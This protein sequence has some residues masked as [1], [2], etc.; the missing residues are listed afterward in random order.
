MIIFQKMKTKSQNTQAI[1]DLNKCPI[2]YIAV[3]PKWLLGVTVVLFL[4]Y[5]RSPI[6]FLEPRFWAEEG[7]G[8]FSF[9]FSHSILES[10]FAPHYGYYGLIQNLGGILATFVPLEYAPLVTTCLAGLIQLL[11]SSYVFF[12]DSP[13]WDTFLKK[14]TIACCIQILCPYECW[15]TTISSQ[16]FLSILAFFILTENAVTQKSKLKWP[17][18]IALSLASLTSP[19]VT[20]LLPAFA[21]KSFKTRLRE[22]WLRVAIISAG[23]FIQ[24]IAFIQTCINSSAQFGGRFRADNIGLLHT[25][26][27]HLSEPF[28]GTY[29]LWCFNYFGIE[30]K[31][32]AFILMA[33]EIY[34][35]FLLIKNLLPGQLQLHVIAFILLTVPA[36]LLSIGMASSARAAF[37]PSII[38]IV[39]MIYEI[40]HV[41]NLR[42]MRLLALCALSTVM[43][44]GFLC[45]DI[46]LFYSGYLP[47]WKDEVKLWR[48]DNNHL[49]RIWPQHTTGDFPSWYMKL[50]SDK[51]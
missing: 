49:I 25:V 48:N 3:V 11:V 4:I 46:K 12:C 47:D 13:Y 44:F 15:L 32:I 23:A 1:Q 17:S 36:I 43:T 22:D 5:Y 7:Q 29:Y 16:Y 19:A 30:I 20:F 21:L 18:R 10:L 38:L 50:S 24:V 39:L 28:F 42:P 40:G 41:R 27:V 2:D 45:H 26:F 6:L 9:A 31:I 14:L 8:Y 34:F 51:K 35:I 37:A 33:F